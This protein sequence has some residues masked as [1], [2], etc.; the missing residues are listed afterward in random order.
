MCRFCGNLGVSTSWNP[1]GLSRPFF[2]TDRFDQQKSLK[3][4][5]YSFKQSRLA[6]FMTTAHVRNAYRNC[7][8]EAPRIIKRNISW[9]K[10][11]T[12]R[13]FLTS[14]KVPFYSLN[15]HPK[16]S[17]CL[18]SPVL[19]LGSSP[20]RPKRRQNACASLSLAHRLLNYYSRQG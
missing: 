14:E 6:R 16:V 4:C 10:Y 8:Y 5:F 17:R 2:F 9:G 11:C 15:I 7:G 20:G 13:P 3:Y 18:W 1:R 19:K 12:Y